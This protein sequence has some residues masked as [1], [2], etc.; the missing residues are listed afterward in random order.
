V[1]EVADEAGEQFEPVV[2]LVRN[3]NAQVC[4]LVLRYRLALLDGPPRR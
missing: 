2:T 3:Q 1:A 4:S